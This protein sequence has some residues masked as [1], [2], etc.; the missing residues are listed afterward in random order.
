[1]IDL[2]AAFVATL[3]GCLAAARLVPARR[4]GFDGFL[5]ARVGRMT[6]RAVTVLLVVALG[7]GPFDGSPAAVLV[8]SLAGWLAAVLLEL[9]SG[10][11]GG[12]GD[13]R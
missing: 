13:G 3:A 6:G 10:T 12:E 8:G 11:P 1:V 2:T 9:R 7:C 5:S 4:G